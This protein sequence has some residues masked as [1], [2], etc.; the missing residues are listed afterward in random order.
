MIASK[1]GNT[2]KDKITLFLLHRT[3]TSCN[4]LIFCPLFFSPSIGDAC[5][6]VTGGVGGVADRLLAAVAVDEAVR[7][8]DDAAVAHLCLRG[9]GVLFGVGVTV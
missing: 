7:S 3:H 4:A 9:V 8:G 5:D 2:S 6:P 1:D